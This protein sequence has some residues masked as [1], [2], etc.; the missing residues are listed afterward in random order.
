MPLSDDEVAYLVGRGGQTK[1]RLENFSLA[2]L[3][4]D[5]D[6]AEL[7]GTDDAL[8]RARRAVVCPRPRRPPAHGTPARP[9][10]P[11]AR[12]QNHAAAAQRRP[13]RH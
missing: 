5:K 6:S 9:R 11:Q 13:H 12:H 7:M 2:R 8:E 4:I 3:N 1:F 10:V